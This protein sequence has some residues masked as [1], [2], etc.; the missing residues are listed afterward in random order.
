MKL[1]NMD[2]TVIAYIGMLQYYLNLP[3]LSELIVAHC[4]LQVRAN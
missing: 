4:E 1:V 2:T 3:G